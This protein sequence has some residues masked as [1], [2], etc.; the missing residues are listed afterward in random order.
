M[1]KWPK[2]QPPASKQRVSQID[3]TERP[4]AFALSLGHDLFKQYHLDDWRLVLDHAR[5][6]AGQCDYR[7]KTISLSRHYVRHATQDHIK[8]TLLH[9]IAHALVGPNHGHDAVWR[10]KARQIGCT[11]TRCHKL[12]FAEAKWTMRCP[13]G[14]FE[15]SRHRRKSH[16]VCAKCKTP[17]IYEHNVM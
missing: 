15:V 17:V 14:C 16:M 12:E 13:N 10:Q 2:K 7:N 4:H 8:D 6:R 11:A 1:F 3:I 9:E 5:R